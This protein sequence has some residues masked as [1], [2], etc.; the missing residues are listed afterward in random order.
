M[1]NPI[2]P[3]E[4]LYA[5]PQGPGDARPTAIQIVK[6]DNL[7]GRLEGKVVL[8]TGATSGIGVETA[9]ALHETGAHVYFTA[10][11]MNKGYS[12]KEHILK[13][14]TGKGKLEV[15][16]MEMESL[17]SVKKAADAFLAKSGGKINILVCNAG[18][19]RSF[20]IC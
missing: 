9:K 12:T 11:D 15:I 8:V 17:E 13:D 3:Y 16:E 14:S 19:L 10:R 1:A 18:E 2:A 6:D 7:V 20:T 4:S 5:D